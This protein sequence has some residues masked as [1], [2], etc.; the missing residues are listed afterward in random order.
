[1]SRPVAP[2]W[3]RMKATSSALSMKFSLLVIVNMFRFMEEQGIG[4]WSAFA[5][6]GALRPRPLSS[7]LRTSRSSI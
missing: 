7:H 1:M 5:V 3:S 4:K 6:V 2:E